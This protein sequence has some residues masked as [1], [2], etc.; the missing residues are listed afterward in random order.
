L[1]GVFVKECTNDL[2]VLQGIYLKH[3]GNTP[4]ESFDA[5]SIIGK[6]KNAVVD[7]QT[8]YV[9]IDDDDIQFIKK[10]FYKWINLEPRKYLKWELYQ[11]LTTPIKKSYN[12]AYFSKLNAIYNWVIGK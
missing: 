1:G 4:P 9:I 10:K 11:K 2:V 8:E 6:I 3:I 7:I 5:L 12:F